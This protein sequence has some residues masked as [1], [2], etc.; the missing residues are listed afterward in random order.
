METQRNNAVQGKEAGRWFGRVLLMAGFAVLAVC[1]MAEARPIICESTGGTQFCPADTRGGVR[2]TRQLS[3]AGCY[4][5][6]TWGYDR[7]GIWVTQGCRARFD[8]E[9]APPDYYGGGYREREYWPYDDAPRRGMPRTIT[10]ESYDSRDNY[11]RVPLRRA[12]VDIVRQL[13]KKPCRYG[14]NWGWDEGGIWVTDGCRAV[15]SI[16]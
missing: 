4:E 14:E 15:F 3:K 16:H 11:C 12:Q 7:H 8:T 6:R 13:S 10:C 2:L 9:D 5:G 1:A